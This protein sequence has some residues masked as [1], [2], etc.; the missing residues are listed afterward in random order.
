MW[1]FL[2]KKDKRRKKREEMKLKFGHRH[3]TASV[4]IIWHKSN[5]E[6]TWKPPH[7]SH[8]WEFHLDHHWRHCQFGQEEGF[9]WWMITRV[10]LQLLVVANEMCE[11]FAND[12]G[13]GDI[14]AL[15]VHFYVWQPCISD[16]TWSTGTG[17]RRPVAGFQRRS[18][19]ECAGMDAKVRVLSS[20]WT[21][22]LSR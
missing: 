10:Q 7:K 14:W 6:G 20:R 3:Q 9:S 13:H 8:Q 16:I 22:V 17:A 4:F 19:Q 2:L 12:T 11:C 5:S 18:H 15:V 1:L 21:L